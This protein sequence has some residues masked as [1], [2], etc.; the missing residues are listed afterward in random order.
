MQRKK[1]AVRKG[2]KVTVRTKSE[3]KPAGLPALAAGN[4]QNWNGVMEKDS[5]TAR[6]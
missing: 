1:A 4:L 6:R 2:L 5:K 3:R